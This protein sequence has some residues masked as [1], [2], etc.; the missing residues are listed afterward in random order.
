MSSAAEG[1]DEEVVVI[2]VTEDSSPSKKYSRSISR[3]DQPVVIHVRTKQSAF[4]LAVP[5]MPMPMA[6]FCCILN[7]IAPGLGTFVSAFTVFC[8]GYTETTPT[9]AFLWNVLV[10]FLQIL[11]F[12]VVVGWIWSIM[13]GMTFV[14]LSADYEHEKELNEKRSKMKE[15]I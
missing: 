6:I 4:R 5:C 8:C 3:S 9:K 2:Q 1:V 11:T 14:T 10:A 7:I 13:W 15:N 12:A